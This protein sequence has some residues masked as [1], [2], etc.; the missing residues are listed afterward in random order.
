MNP[1]LSPADLAAYFERIG[2]AGPRTAS[3]AT[4]RALHLLHPQAIP[5]ENLDSLLG[6]TPQLDLDSLMKKL[7]R[8]RRGGYCYEQN[9]LFRAVL[10]T[11]GFETTGLAARV[12]W[13]NPSNPMPSRTHMALL[14]ENDEETWLADVGFGGMTPSA[15]LRFETGREQG[16]PH[17]PYRIDL[18]DRGDY[19]LQVKLGNAPDPALC[20]ASGR[21]PGTTSKGIWKPIYRFDLEPQFPSDYS[22]ANHYVSTHPRSLFVNTLM[23]ARLAP[24]SRLALMDCRLTI[25]GATSEQREL[26]SVAELRAL[27][28]EEF[29]LALPDTNG[30]ATSAELDVLLARVIQRGS[31]QPSQQPSH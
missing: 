14:V 4:L 18:I 30:K 10:D 26:A 15:P 12:L 23:A 17:E 29:G 19:L 28:S 6:L 24:T 3:A 2:Y 25:H 16:T 9:L 20:T 11:L 21:T 1:T 22:V 7:V 27:L 13:D 5:F 31:Q 8:E